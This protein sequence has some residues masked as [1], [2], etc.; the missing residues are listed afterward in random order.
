[1][2]KTIM[3]LVAT[4]FAHAQAL[5]HWLGRQARL[6]FRELPHFGDAIDMATRAKMDNRGQLGFGTVIAAVV[7]V[8]AVML[9]V[10]VVDQMDSALG[11]PDS[12]ALSS[13]SDDVLS[14]FADMTSL[15]GPLL[16]VAIAVVIIGL[17]QR[18]RG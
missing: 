12:S 13:S 6:T 3:A 4:I 11:N 10:I 5:N 15:I 9:A 17:V 16:I 7:V 1:M 2:R 8:I 18:L 14:G